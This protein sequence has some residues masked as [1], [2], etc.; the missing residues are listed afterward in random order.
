MMIVGE[1]VV[2]N[3]RREIDEA[4]VVGGFEARDEAPVLAIDLRAIAG[5]MRR[6]SGDSDQER[7]NRIPIALREQAFK[8]G[9]RP[10][11]GLIIFKPAL[12]APRVERAGF[13]RGNAGVA[14]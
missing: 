7:G 6:G 12:R 5:A 2:A 3:A 13:V 1:V 8:R 11:A 4:R 9:E 14:I 10:A